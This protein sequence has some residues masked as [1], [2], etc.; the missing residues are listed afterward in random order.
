MDDN[1]TNRYL[2][3]LTESFK[4]LCHVSCQEIKKKLAFS[5]RHFNVSELGFFFNL[6]N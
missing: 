1:L 6:A 2:L 4:T 5:D 3:L